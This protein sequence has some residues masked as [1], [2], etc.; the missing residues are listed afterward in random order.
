MD[1]KGRWGQREGWLG[2]EKAAFRG[3]S[4]RETKWW[5][6]WLGGA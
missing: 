5:G 4:V 1:W 2:P 3:R 6:E